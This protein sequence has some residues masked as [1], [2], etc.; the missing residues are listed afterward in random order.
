MLIQH[1]ER[2]FS[3]EIANEIFRIIVDWGRYAEIFAY[4]DRT[5]QLSLEDPK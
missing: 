5:E 4:D 3:V 2:H 1:L